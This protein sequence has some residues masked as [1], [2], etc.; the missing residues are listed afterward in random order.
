MTIASEKHLKNGPKTATNPQTSTTGCLTVPPLLKNKKYVHGPPFL[1][2]RVLQ[3]Y[4]D[5]NS[6]YIWSRSPVSYHPPTPPNVMTLS[7][8][9][10][11]RMTIWRPPCCFEG[12]LAEKEYR[13]TSGHIW[14]LEKLSCR[15]KKPTPSNLIGSMMIIRVLPIHVPPCYAGGNTLSL[16]SIET[17]YDLRWSFGLT[18]PCSTT[19]RAHL[20][21]WGNTRTRATFPTHTKGH[22]PHVGWFYLWAVQYSE[23]SNIYMCLVYQGSREYWILDRLQTVKKTC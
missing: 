21:V 4:Q 17:I 20:S 3:K 23:E 16:L 14:S 13:I 2:A 11:A 12:E 6:P 15:N 22:N 9:P 5:S 8:L 18:H 7:T 10:L 1:C 19:L